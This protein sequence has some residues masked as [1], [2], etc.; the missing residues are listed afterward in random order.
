MKFTRVIYVKQKNLNFYYVRRIYLYVC[1]YTVTFVTLIS[2]S[3]PIRKTFVVQTQHC[4]D[5]FGNLLK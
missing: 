2:C 4:A 1:R 5:C 3:L